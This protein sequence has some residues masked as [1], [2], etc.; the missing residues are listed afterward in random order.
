M[1]NKIKAVSFDFWNTLF[2]DRGGATYQ[3]VRLKFFLETV[4]PYHD[5]CEEQ[6]AAAFIHSSEVS[7]RIWS[8]QYRT[9][10]A[11]ERL[12]LVLAHLMLE[13]PDE[14]LDHLARYSS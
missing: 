4:S 7:N 3:S 2:R 1:N 8:E 12:E 6:V 5:C 9:P 14:I 10:N 11:R 13:L